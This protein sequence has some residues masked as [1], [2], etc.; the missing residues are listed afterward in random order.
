MLKRAIPITF[1]TCEYPLSVQQPNRWVLLDTFDMLAPEFDTPRRPMAVLRWPDTAG[2]SG[3]EVFLA[4]H[5][6]GRGRK[7]S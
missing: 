7:A 5:L 6:I 3:I 4:G 1:Y 2:L